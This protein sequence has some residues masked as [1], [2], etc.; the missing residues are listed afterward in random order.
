M[1]CQPGSIILRL[2]ACI[3]QLLHQ[4]LNEIYVT[5]L[6][7]LHGTSNLLY[8]CS[9]STCAL[10]WNFDKKPWLR[11][12][13][14]L[15]EW[16][17]EIDTI[18]RLRIHSWTAILMVISMDGT[19][20]CSSPIGS[21]EHRKCRE[22]YSFG[23]APTS[24]RTLPDFHWLFYE[25]EQLRTYQNLAQKWIPGKRPIPDHWHAPSKRYVLEQWTCLHSEG[26]SYTSFNTPKPQKA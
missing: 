23:A 15:T 18:S 2:L 3:I 19:V 1:L 11:P 26:N 8:Q 4:L 5:F 24:A 22:S 9:S 7:E 12:W 16:S 14:V 20:V 25:Q 17:V 21:E 6:G 10:L 13:Q